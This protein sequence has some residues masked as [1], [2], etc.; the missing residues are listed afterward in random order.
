[1]NPVSTGSCPPSTPDPPLSSCCSPSPP[2]P[3]NRWPSV[4]SPDRSPCP[5]LSRP[6]SRRAWLGPCC[7]RMLIFFPFFSLRHLL[8]LSVPCRYLV[9]C[10]PENPKIEWAR[11]PDLN[12]SPQVLF[13]SLY[14]PHLNRR[15]F[16]RCSTTPTLLPKEFLRPSRPT[17]PLSP[18]PTSLS[19]KSATTC[20]A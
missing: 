13:T 9:S 20:L 18:P 4:S 11:F 8:I 15:N 6:G 10:P 7:L 14:V 2:R 1:M 5:S 12:V 3:D 19:L 17:G 16:S